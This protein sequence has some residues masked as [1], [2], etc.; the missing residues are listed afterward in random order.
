ML[1]VLSVLRLLHQVY[2]RSILISVQ[3]IHS[4]LLLVRKLHF[5]LCYPSLETIKDAILTR[6]SHICCC[7]NLLL[8]I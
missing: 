2:I 1:R 6:D 7:M 4:H 8:L 5:G 3:Q